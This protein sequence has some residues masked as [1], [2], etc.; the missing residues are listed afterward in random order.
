VVTEV[1]AVTAAASMEAV[2]EA[3]A[4]M[5]VDFAEAGGAEAD[6]VPTTADTVI[7]TAMAA[8]TTTMAGAIW[9]VSAC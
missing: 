9:F 4:S 3:V 5:V 7:L 6:L 8:T 1:A 2:T